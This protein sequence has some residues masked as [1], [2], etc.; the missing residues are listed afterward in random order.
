ML[1][2]LKPVPFV[3]K[4]T[5]PY[6]ILIFVSCHYS[7]IFWAEVIK[8]LNDLDIKIEQLSDKD[9]NVWHSEVRERVIC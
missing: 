6:S 7:K 9:N 2:H 8:W 5:S 4:W 3:V 1:Y